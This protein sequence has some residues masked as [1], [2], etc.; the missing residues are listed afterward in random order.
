MR[1]Y[2]RIV[3]QSRADKGLRLANYFIDYIV[4]YVFFFGFGIISAALTYVDVYF[5]YELTL[6]MSE[7]NRLVDYAMTAS[8]YFAYIFSI[9]Y[10]TKG[11]SLGKYITGTK[12][13]AVDGTL[14]TT[15]DFLIRNIS[16]IVPFDGLSFLG[17][18]GWHDSWSETR[19]VKIKDFERMKNGDDD[20]QSIGKKDEE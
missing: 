17:E 3:E 1:K 6:K 16:R 10:F 12:V 18:T 4:V 20:I 14:P 5:L 9:E 7:V 13:V 11:R 19:V 2:L 15:K 8:V